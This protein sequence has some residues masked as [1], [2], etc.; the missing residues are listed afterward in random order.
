MPEPRQLSAKVAVG[1]QPTV[2]DLREL[3]AQGFVAVVNLRTAG[4]AGQPLSPEAEGFAAQ[5]AGLIY[6]HLPVA[7]PE[8]DPDH[9]HRLRAAIAAAQGPVYVHCGAGQRACALGLLATAGPGIHGDDLI[10][11][12][13][14]AGLPVTDERLASF[15]R[16]RTERD[17][18]ELLQAM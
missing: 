18:W 17:G 12:A 15:V 11:R 5:E 16:T 6:S 9:V 1:G 14:A 2:D 10:A 8:I 3:K 7:I 13:K 4:E